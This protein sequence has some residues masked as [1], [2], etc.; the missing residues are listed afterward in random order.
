MAQETKQ[1][2]EVVEHRAVA[3]GSHLLVDFHGLPTSKPAAEDEAE[4]LRLTYG[5]VRIE[6][7]TITKSP[8]EAIADA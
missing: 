5:S 1:V 2:E 8:W 7:R 3:T 6:R 4:H